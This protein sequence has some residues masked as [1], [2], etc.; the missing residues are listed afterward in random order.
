[1][2]ALRLLRPWLLV[3]AAAVLWAASGVYSVDRAEHGVVLTFGRVTADRVPPGLHYRAPWPISRV[4]RVDTS[5]VH[6]MS[7]GFK[8][9]DMVM[10]I[11]TPPEQSRWLTGDTN[12]VELR[13]VLLYRAAE[14][15]AY[16][17]SAD[18]P[19]ELV[20]RAGEAVLT[21]LVGHVGVEV[22]TSGRGSLV[23]RSQVATQQLLDSWDCGIVLTSVSFESM[24]PPREV[25]D[26]FHDVQS[27]KA[28]EARMLE[29]A[30]AYANSILPQAR[31]EAAEVLSEARSYREA[32]LGQARGWSAR[33]GA[34]AEA[35]S[36]SPRETRRRL[37]LETAERALSRGELVIVHP[38]DGGEQ[39]RTVLVRD[40]A[41]SR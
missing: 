12:I 40:A 33:F 25:V 36:A 30:D 6:T 37:Y 9:R 34:L 15:A 5:T 31:G 27:A 20:R 18:A 11:P 38:G 32:R 16:S 8:I 26:A 35:Y 19:D 21:D 10:D 7:V 41:G 4:V 28:D 29:E 39:Q 2:S 13:M 1:V 23:G 17:F 24:D 22:M 3:C 14:P